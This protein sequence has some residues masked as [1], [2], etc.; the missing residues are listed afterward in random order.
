MIAAAREKARARN[1]VDAR[2]PACALVSTAIFRLTRDPVYFPTT[3][4]VPDVRRVF[5]SP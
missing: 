5:N 3:L 4:F 1:S 2:E